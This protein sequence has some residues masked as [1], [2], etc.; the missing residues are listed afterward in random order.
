MDGYFCLVASLV[1][2]YLGERLHHVQCE[3]AVIGLCPSKTP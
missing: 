1:S 3:A 2:F